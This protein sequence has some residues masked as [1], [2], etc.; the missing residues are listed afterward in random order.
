M[1]KNSLAYFS[2]MREVKKA[3]ANY[4]GALEYVVISE[5]S[6]VALRLDGLQICMAGMVGMG[7]SHPY[8]FYLT[9]IFLPFM[10]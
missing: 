9:R 6:I 1:K 3:Q 8:P 5:A 2:Q 7:Y 10:I 4:I